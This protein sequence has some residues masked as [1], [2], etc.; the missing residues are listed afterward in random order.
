MTQA[1][2]E[3][4]AAPLGSIVFSSAD[5]PKALGDRARF[6]LWYEM[7]NANVA[8][9]QLSMSEKLRFHMV[10]KAVALGPV[11][12]TNATGTVTSAGRTKGQ[13]SSDDHYTIHINTGVTPMGGNYATRDVHVPMGGALM[14]GSAE[15]A[16]SGRESN[17]WI[18]LRLPRRLV[19]A[20]FSGVEAREGVVIAPDQ[21]ALQLLRHYL[22][23]LDGPAVPTTAPVVEHLTN[24]IID[25]AGLIVGARGE[26]AEQA[27]LRGLRRARLT[28]VLARIGRDF[29]NPALSAET[30][31]RDLGMS[32]R[33]V[34]DLLAATKTTFSERVLELRL[35]HAKKL[36]GAPLANAL[37]IGEIVYASGFSDISYFNRCFRRRYGCTPGAAR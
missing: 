29:T 14:I 36:L 15:Q 19:D 28:A 9:A 25:L 3:P 6:N 10:F 33:H 1:R 18:D 37:R 23:V 22:R 17:S 13:A 31:G 21:E 26:E 8:P 16:L 34:Q 7:F 30:V 32:A 12:Y 11:T 27:G 5:L 4:M 2:F 35:Q 20:V 24:T